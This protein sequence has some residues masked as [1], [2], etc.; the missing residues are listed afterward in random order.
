MVCTA[1]T[2]GCFIPAERVL[3]SR[4]NVAGLHAAANT[5]K[6]KTVRIYP[7]YTPLDPLE[8][9]AITITATMTAATATAI[10]SFL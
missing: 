1:S 9:A 4:A 5:S 7:Q 6:A 2:G 8:P 3:S 10:Q